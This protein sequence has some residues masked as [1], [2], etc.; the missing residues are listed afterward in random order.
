MLW[1]VMGGVARR[2][3]ARNENAM[4]TV[5]EW[6]DT[7]MENGFYITEPNLADESFLAEIIAK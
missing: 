3:W 6:N 5:R 2:S 4:S 1:D 7:Q